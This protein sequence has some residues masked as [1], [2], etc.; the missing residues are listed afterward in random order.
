MVLDNYP[1]VICGYA[2]ACVFNFNLSERIH[3]GKPLSGRGDKIGTPS[4]HRHNGTEMGGIP[5]ATLLMK[6]RKELSG[7]EE[8][9]QSLE[10]VTPNGL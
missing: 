7:E 1:T 2:S 3:F 6:F 9:G 8:G 5:P 4:T 10:T